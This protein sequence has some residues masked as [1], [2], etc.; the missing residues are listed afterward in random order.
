MKKINNLICAAFAVFSIGGNTFAQTS[1]LCSTDEMVKRAL[2]NNPQLKQEYEAEQMRL[3]AIDR[4]VYQNRSLKN[5]NR[6]SQLLPIYTIPVVFHIIHQNGPEN[7]SD[8][9]IM[10]QMRILNED[11]RKQNADIVD[12]VPAFTSIAADCEI[13][14]RLAQKDPSGNCHNGIDRIFSAET[15]IGDD[16]SKLN[17]WPRSKY[18]NIW[19]VK[20]ISSGAA[21]YAYLPGTAFPTSV[22]GIIILSNYIG[23]IGTGSVNASRA[24]THEIGH[25]LNLQHVWGNT[26]SPGVACGNDGVTDTPETEG[27]ANV[28]PLNDQN[29]NPGVVEN[30]QNFLEYSYCSNMY[31]SGQKTRMRSALN[32]STGQRSSLWTTTNL[33]AT[34]LSTPSVL[35]QADFLS[36]NAN[37]TVCAGGSLTF[38]DI[39][40]NGNPTS[41]SWSFPGGTPSTSTDSIPVIQYNT[42][43]LYNVSLTVTNGSGSVNTT[44]LNYVTVN[45]G[46]AAYNASIY[47]EGF[48]TTTIPGSE[49]LVRNQSPGGNTWVLTSA[50]AA[51]G[52]KSVMLTNLSTYGAYVD[53]LIGPSV[54]MTAI[55]GSNPVIT[56]KTAYAQRTSTSADKLQLYVSSNCGLTWALRKSMTGT[57]LASGGVVTGSFV[58]TSTQWFTQ[59]ANLISYASQTNLYFMFRFTSDGG[60]SIYIDD[61]N[62]SGTSLTGVNEST[63][64]GEFNIYPNPIDENT[65]VQ[66]NLMSKQSVDIKIHDILGREISSV[67][68]GE[69]TE[70]EHLISIGDQIKLG[71]GI[72]LVKVS[73]NGES[74]SKKMI[75]K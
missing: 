13:E 46:T 63:T 50:A 6:E 2:A 30:L 68:N 20:T 31:T 56:F 12:V 48:E 10:D 60:N 33:A 25:F 5:T 32:S 69:L 51:S 19:V 75:V 26:N 66:L 28:C 36:S 7:I 70:G 57:A 54:D 16:G 9:Q 53:E 45:S 23:S 41:W 58:P 35:C 49:W 24:L 71:A 73:M 38:N 21:G 15:N 62:I 1:K 8:A 39:S 65:L 59:T 34:G 44:K 3:E 40:W 42:P 11:F 22:D 27:H 14:F 43:G 47:Q 17:P 52:S 4:D 61:I 67:F 37:N 29:C 72:Y 18:L 74:V 64:N 55:A